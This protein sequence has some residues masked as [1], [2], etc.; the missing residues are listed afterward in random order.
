MTGLSFLRFAKT[1]LETLV[2]VS[3]RLEIEQLGAHADDSFTCFEGGSL[4]L[5]VRK[6]VRALSNLNQTQTLCV[7]KPDPVTSSV[8][9]VIPN[10]YLSNFIGGKFK[11]VHFNLVKKHRRDRRALRLVAH[12]EVKETVALR[13]EDALDLTSVLQLT[14]KS[15]TVIAVLVLRRGQLGPPGTYLQTR[16]FLI[17]YQRYFLFFYNFGLYIRVVKK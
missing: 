7:L 15:E 17:F 2:Q 16:F 12:E 13:F 11:L 5:Q 3:A 1:E 10:R 4:H 8:P 9:R 14:R 6:V